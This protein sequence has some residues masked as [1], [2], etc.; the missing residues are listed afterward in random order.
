M[1]EQPELR[2]EMLDVRHEITAEQPECSC[3]TRLNKG[4]Q[5]GTEEQPFDLMMRGFE[6]LKM[7]K[8]GLD[9]R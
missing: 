3:Y 9:L 5:R 6:N 4:A 8:Q 2:C 1:G 7:E